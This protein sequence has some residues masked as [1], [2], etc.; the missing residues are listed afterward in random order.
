GSCGS[1][2]RRESSGSRARSATRSARRRLGGRAA[3]RRARAAGGVHATESESNRASWDAIPQSN[4]RGHD[5][6]QT[7]VVERADGFVEQ[8]ERAWVALR[9]TAAQAR[10]EQRDAQR[11]DVVPAR[12]GA[13]VTE[14]VRRRVAVEILAV[15]QLQILDAF[16]ELL[17]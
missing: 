5:A 7:A 4:G 12:D 10:D 17:C 9:Q 2:R 3:A 15:Q 14:I 16:G 13:R 1:R 6:A 11:D 8:R